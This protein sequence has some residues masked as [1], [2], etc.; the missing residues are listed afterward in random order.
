MQDAAWLAA[1]KVLPC[2]SSMKIHC[3][4]STPS[5]IINHSATGYSAH[6]FKCK[7]HPYEAKGERSLRDLKREREEL[8]AMQDKTI[9]IPRDFTF[10]IPTQAAWFLKYGISFDDAEH[11]NFGYSKF[12]DRV[13]IP[14]WDE[15]DVLRAVQMRDYTGKNPPKWLSSSVKGKPATYYTHPLTDNPMIVVTED[16]I[17]A[18]KVGKVTPAISIVGS[19]IGDIRASQYVARWSKIVIWLDGD[20]AGRLGAIDMEKQL[21]LQG[22]TEVYRVR[23]PLDP[24]C[25]SLTEIKNF[26]QEEAK[27]SI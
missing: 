19:D 4:S 5:M 23:T 1:A 21:L 2:G 22:A 8:A 18:I 15:A 16:I 11:Y 7:Q 3:C 25:Y 26:I 10:D 13:I 24:K 20:K 6:C 14:V 27:C 9:R 17:S 12:F